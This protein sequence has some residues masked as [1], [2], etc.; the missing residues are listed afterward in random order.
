[1]KLELYNL[2]TSKVWTADICVF[3]LVKIKCIVCLYA[4][5]S[6]LL[7]TGNTILLEKN[8]DIARICYQETTTCAEIK[9]Q[10]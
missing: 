10:N 3:V 2:E 6:Q 9:D 5:N 8:S 4:D 7:S 1:M